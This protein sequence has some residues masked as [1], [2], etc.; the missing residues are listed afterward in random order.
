MFVS[1]RSATF[2]L[3][4]AGAV[5]LSACQNLPFFKT[6]ATSAASQ[7]AASSAATNATPASSAPRPATTLASTPVAPVNPWWEK[8]KA[9]HVSCEMGQGF[10]VRKVDTSSSV[11]L[12]WKKKDYVLKKVNT[13]TGAYRYEDAASGLVLIQI[14]AK[15]LLLNS[16][17]GQRLADECKPA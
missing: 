9:G 2:L 8:L 6:N 1:S 12:V 17:L 15:M 5:A 3:A 4:I 11:E 13:T 10:D 14:P 16:K 7:P